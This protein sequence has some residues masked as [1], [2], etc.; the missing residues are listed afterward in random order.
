MAI[1]FSFA[2]REMAKRQ[3]ARPKLSLPNEESDFNC[4]FN[5]QAEVLPIKTFGTFPQVLCPERMQV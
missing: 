2:K 5:L 3:K 4:A 1:C